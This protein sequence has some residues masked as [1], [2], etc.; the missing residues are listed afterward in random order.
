LPTTRRAPRSDPPA[1]VLLPKARTDLRAIYD[2]I[3]A[4]GSQR[5]ALAYVQRLEAWLAG[6]D[7]GAERGTQRDDIQ[8]GLR[9]IGFSQFLQ[10]RRTAHWESAT[11]A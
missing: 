2:H 5:A 1:V 8:R 11:A 6:F 9:T 10:E 3:A 4:E 7:I